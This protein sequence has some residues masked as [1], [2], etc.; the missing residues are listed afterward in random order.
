MS[1]LVPGQ[2]VVRGTDGEPFVFY[3]PHPHQAL[4]HASTAPNVLMEGSAGTGKSLSLRMEGYMRCLSIPR[5]TALLVRRKMPE[6]KMSHLDKI[7]FEIKQLGLPDNA[8]HRT[9][10]TI[11]FPNGSLFVFRQVEDD[12]TLSDFLSSEWCLLL[13]D[14]LS[15]F[16]LKQFKFLNSRLRTTIPGLRPLMRG[17]TNPIGDGAQWV[18]KYF[19]D[20]NVTPEEDPV[21]NPAN[22]ISLH[23]TLEDNPSVDL[24]EYHQRLMAMP[25]DAHRQAYRYGIWVMEGQYFSDWAAQL[26]GKPWHVIPKM[27]EYHGVPIQFASHIEIVRV[28]DWGFSSEGNPGVCL[29]FACLPDGSAIGFQEYV[30][31]QTLP[32]DAA[33]EILRRSAGLKVRMTVGDTSMWQEHR[34]PSIAETFAKHGLSMIEADKERE[35]GWMEMHSWLRKTV[36]DGSGPRP[37]ISFL[38]TGCPL[39]IRSVPSMVVD[40]K[41]PQDIVTVGVEDDAPDCIRYFVMSRPGR[42]REAAPVVTPQLQEIRKIITQKKRRAFRLGRES[43]RP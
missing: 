14:E 43:M 42:S 37:R 25:S 35:A 10:H 29:W 31:K 1:N 9:D 39:A 11:R 5:F 24:D 6:L 30:F 18:K 12:A 38:E 4:F 34:G 28:V 36:D 3:K 16:T 21:Y 41:H 15:T 22:Y 23:S 8:F 33:R 40:P 32:E 26:E 13:W 27:P 20:K 2:I 17:G 7:P 19:I